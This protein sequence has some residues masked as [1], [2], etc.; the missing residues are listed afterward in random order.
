MEK[1]LTR[2]EKRAIY[3]ESYM[4]KYREEN[5]EAILSQRMMCL[6][7]TLICSCGMVVKRNNQRRHEQTLK[8]KRALEQLSS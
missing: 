1:Q 4:V 2:K 8:H 6:E 3:M 7:K 5:E